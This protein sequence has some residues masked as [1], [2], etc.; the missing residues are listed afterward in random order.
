MTDYDNDFHVIKF[1]VRQGLQEP[2][3]P[4][5]IITD[6]RF[7]NEFDAVKK[8][9]GI[10]IRVTRHNHPNDLQPSTHP[11]ETAL[12]THTFDYEIINDG[13]IEELINKV[14]DILKQNQII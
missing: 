4:N 13:T 2:E 3:Y 10:T 7:P 9:G 14:S 8:R 1:S 6:M 11:S 12:D 5:W